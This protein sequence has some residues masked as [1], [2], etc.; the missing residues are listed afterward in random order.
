M[1]YED[2]RGRT[3]ACLALVED[4]AKPEAD[5]VELINKCIDDSHTGFCHNIVSVA[6]ISDQRR[7]LPSPV[8]YRVIEIPTLSCVC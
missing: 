7:L 3:Y 4:T 5:K 6:G 2:H 1:I 8:A